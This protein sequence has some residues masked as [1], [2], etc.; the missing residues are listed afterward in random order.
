VSPDYLA[1]V[2]V[3]ISIYA[4]LAISLNIVAGYAGQPNLAQGAFF[5]IGAYFAAVLSAHGGWSF[6]ATIPVAL[7]TAGGAG[8]V[9]GAISLRLREDFLAVTT[10]GLN[11]VVVA[12]FQY[13]PFFGGAVGVYAIPLPTIGNHQF[14]NADFL[15]VGLLMLVLVAGISVYLER[16]WFGTALLAIKDDEAAAAATGVPVAPYKVGAFALSAGLGGMA[17]ALY[18]PFL[19]AVTPTSFGFSESVVI[20]AMLMLGGIGG[21]AGALT[22]AIILGALPEV[23][24]FVS[25]YRLLAF[26]A[27]L[28]LV[29]RFQPEGLLG[30]GGAVAGAVSAILDRVTRRA[31]GRDGAGKVPGSH[32]AA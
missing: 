2:A 20:L 8:L 7:A 13:V 12:M 27:I 24:R 23:F 22:G 14:G 9:L 21:V 3:T 26:G 18:A 6:W 11:F 19:S 32:G 5:G 4:M 25:D 30:E 17:G 1:V 16:T 15:L 28:V 31:R 29:L 10:I